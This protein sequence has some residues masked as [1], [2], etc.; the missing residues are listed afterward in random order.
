[1]KDPTRSFVSVWQL[2]DIPSQLLKGKMG[3]FQQS[4]DGNHRKDYLISVCR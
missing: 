3:N 1:M 2:R 4:K